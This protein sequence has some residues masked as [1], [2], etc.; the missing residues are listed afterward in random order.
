M[1]WP[2][3]ASALG[4]ALALSAVAAPSGRADTPW[5]QFRGPT[6]QGLTESTG[7]PLKWSE[8]ENVAWKTAIHGKAWS[9]PIVWGPHVWLTTATPDGRQLSVLCVDKST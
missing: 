4:L 7:V 1:K 6:A 8:K 3:T 5:S 2:T 9:S